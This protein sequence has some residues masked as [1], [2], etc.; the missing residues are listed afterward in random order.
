MTNL[1]SYVTLTRASKRKFTKL[2]IDYFELEAKFYS[3]HEYNISYKKALNMIAHRHG[4]ENWSM[5]KQSSPSPQ[6]D[7]CKSMPL[8]AS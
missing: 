7:L 1:N 2:E 8:G 6:C 4:Y 5:L 3:I